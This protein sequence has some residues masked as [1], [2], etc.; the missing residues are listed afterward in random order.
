MYIKCHYLHLILKL[1]HG[2]HSKDKLTGLSTKNIIS[3]NIIF[4]RKVIYYTGDKYLN[5]RKSILKKHNFTYKKTINMYLVNEL[6][7]FIINPS[8]N[9]SINNCLFGAVKLTRHK[10]KER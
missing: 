7:N 8:C 3:P 6:H 9:F 4:A 2:F 5:F 1:L 10:S